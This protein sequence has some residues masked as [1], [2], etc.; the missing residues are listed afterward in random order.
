MQYLQNSVLREIASWGVNLEIFYKYLWRHVCILA[1]ARSRYEEPSSVPTKIGALAGFREMFFGAQQ[2]SREAKDTAISYIQDYSDSFWISTDSK[3][4]KI[5]SEIESRLRNDNTLSA[6]LG[7]SR[8]AFGG[9]R[10]EHAD[11][12]TVSKME[13]ET[14]A[15][16]QQIVSQFQIADLNKVIDLV[17]KYS[18]DDPQNPH[19][20]VIDDLDKNWMPDDTLY[21]ELLKSLLLVVRELNYRLKNAKI[22]VALREDIYQRVYQQTSKQEAQ[23][24]KWADVQIKV[25]WDKEQLVDLVDRRLKEVYRGQYTQSPPTLGQLL[26]PIQRKNADN[27]PTDYVLERTLMRPRDV[28]DFINRCFSESSEVSR[29]TW[30]DLRAAEV[31]YSEARLQ[32]VVDEWANCYYGLPASFALLTKL[33][34]KFTPADIAD[35]DLLE[36]FVDDAVAKSDWL[37]AAADMFSR[38][39]SGVANAKKEILHAWFTA[40]LV[41]IKDPVSHRL[42]MSLDRAF[43]PG[44]DVERDRI[45]TVLKMVRS[46]LGINE[47]KA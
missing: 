41:G 23:R 8:A 7:V 14:V 38:G 30:S 6:H 32:A 39:D 24:E 20:L 19:F 42:L 28:I 22:V 17:T 2:N 33:G 21:L 40:G 46:A 27:D 11:T 44:K 43:I 12:K 31:G 45:Y 4:K 18:F 34:S 25:R 26:P 29:L 16:A 9:S 15:R 35:D 5:T 10:G 36:L 37:K 1:L 13:E 3:V 47:W